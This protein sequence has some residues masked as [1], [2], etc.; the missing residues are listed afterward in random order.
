MTLTMRMT[1]VWIVVIVTV[2]FAARRI[3]QLNDPLGYVN[4]RYN[5]HFQTTYFDGT[6]EFDRISYDDAMHA[7]AEFSRLY[8][9]SFLKETDP[10]VVIKH[11]STQRRLMHRHIHTLRHYF[12]N[13]LLLDKRVLLGL[14]SI[15][16]GMAWCIADVARR[17]PH[18]RLL[19]GAG[20]QHNPVRSVDDF[21]S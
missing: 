15:D 5:P 8:Q 18:T 2:V 17:Y 20:I 12:P 21:W 11:M 13:D 6:R 9:T 19:Y 7:I 3:R 10:A 4:T 16:G 1:V 14:E